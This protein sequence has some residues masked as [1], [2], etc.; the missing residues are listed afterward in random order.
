VC[1]GEVLLRAVKAQ[2]RVELRVHALLMSTPDRGERLALRSGHIT[3]E[4]INTGCHHC[5]DCTAGLDVSEKIQ[6][7]PL[8]DVSSSRLTGLVGKTTR[9]MR[10]A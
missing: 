9:N 2:A 1:E 3:P 8:C 6:F 10:A 5:V 7:L 4:E